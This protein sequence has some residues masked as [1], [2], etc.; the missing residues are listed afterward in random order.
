MLAT[1]LTSDVELATDAN[2]ET[3]RKIE[4]NTK[5]IECTLGPE[6]TFCKQINS[7]NASHGSFGARMGEVAP[8]LNDLGISVKSLKASG[9]YLVH[10]LKGLSASLREYQTSYQNPPLELELS[11]KVAENANLEL[12]LQKV[13]LEAVSLRESLNQREVESQSL[14]KL[15][16][17]LSAKDQFMK[18][19][20]IELESENT[21]LRE[22]AKLSQEKAREMIEKQKLSSQEDIKSRHNEQIEVLQKEKQNLEETSGEMIGQLQQVQDSLVSSKANMAILS[23]MKAN[24]KACAQKMIDNQRQERADLVCDPNF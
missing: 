20:E 15:I 8:M 11:N 3:S 22:Q 23:L 10:E 2:L 17:E 21:S 24:L 1:H 6:S 18:K 19:R 4:E 9:D 16:E 14:Q 12:R 7:C 5:A 13:G